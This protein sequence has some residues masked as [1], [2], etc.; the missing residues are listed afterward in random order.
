MTDE[1][2]LVACGW[3]LM[4]ENERGMV[5]ACRNRLNFVPVAEAVETQVQ[6]D[7]ARLAFVLSR[8]AVTLTTQESPADRL[9][10]FKQDVDMD[11]MNW[12][13]EKKR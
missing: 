3:V 7:R 2:Y 12:Q 1:E 5:A 10:P 8:S 9:N 13:I 11:I 4:R 6:E